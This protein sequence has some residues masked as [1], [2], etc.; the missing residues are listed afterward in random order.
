MS[1]ALLTARTVHA[2][3]SPFRHRFAYRLWMLR[4]DIDG[5]PDGP[6]FRSRLLHISPRDHAARDGSPMRPWVEAR[7]AEAGLADCAARVELVAMPR[8]LGYAFNPISL[9]LC[10]R[11]DGTLGAVIYEVKNTFG[12]QHAYVARIGPS[13]SGAGTATHAASKRMHVSPFFD[14]QGGYRF[15]LGVEDD[16]FS[17][18][19]RYGT[20][21]EPRLVATL[22]G[23][24]APA[25][26]P[27][28][29]GAMARVPFVTL[30]VIT[31]IHWHALILWRRG[32]RFHSKPENPPAIASSTHEPA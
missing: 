23:R 9:F 8:V 17:L 7:L 26:T 25:T 28:L 24:Y 3:L 14:M 19:I 31:L 20:A 2:R 22:S 32:A 6:L 27:A 13:V 15:A 30:K 21:S 18:V 4:S 1:T 10:R 16:R 11:A 29:L 5:P 12:D